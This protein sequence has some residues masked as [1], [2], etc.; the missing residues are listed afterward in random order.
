MVRLFLFVVV[1][2]HVGSTMNSIRTTTG[3]TGSTAGRNISRGRHHRKFVNIYIN[4]YYCTLDGDCLL[5]IFYTHIIGFGGS[6]SDFVV[7]ST[8]YRTIY[9]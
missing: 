7:L 9:F 1:V 5:F 8:P 3:S 6:D 4:I 2:V